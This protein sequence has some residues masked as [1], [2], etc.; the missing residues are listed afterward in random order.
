MTGAHDSYAVGY[1]GLLP[2]ALFYIVRLLPDYRT[3][4]IIN[5]NKIKGSRFLR[6]QMKIF[7]TNDDGIKAEGLRRLARA[8]RKYGDLYIFAPKEQQSGKSHSI[9][10]HSVCDAVRIERVYGYPVEAEQVWTV[11]GTPADCVRMGFNCILKE[12]PDIV[13]SG[14]NN[15][16]NVGYES[17]YSGTV[18][19]AMESLVYSVPAIAY[20]QYDESDYSGFER[21]FEEVTDSLLSSSIGVNQIWNVNFPHCGADSIEGLKY[22]CVPARDMFYHCGYKV[23]KED[24]DN[25]LIDSLFEDRTSGEPGTDIDALLNN[26]IS[27]GTMTS[28][29]G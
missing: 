11:A 20:S 23:T 18:G 9:T 5:R 8:A 6:T 27:I 26:Q 3:G 28:R 4:C 16:Y 19:A 24:E 22:G 21:Y 12:K 1:D 25:Y 15:G 17:L 2:R 29:V 14:V 13:F 7:I 10:V